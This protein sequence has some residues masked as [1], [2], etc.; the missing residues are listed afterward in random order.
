MH[1]IHQYWDHCVW[2]DDG[3]VGEWECLLPASELSGHR[4][5]VQWLKRQS[6][7]IKAWDAAR[8]GARM[9]VNGVGV[10]NDGNSFICCRALAA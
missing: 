4:S 8:V 7:T 10:G 6:N 5:L 1:G 2:L 3:V 9:D